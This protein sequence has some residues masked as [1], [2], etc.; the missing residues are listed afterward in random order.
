MTLNVNGHI[1]HLSYVEVLRNTI[2]IVLLNCAVL[3]F[4]IPSAGSISCSRH[5]NNFID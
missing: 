4:D 3:N 2:K 5:E 1:S